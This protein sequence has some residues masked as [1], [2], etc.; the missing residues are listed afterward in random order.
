MRSLT[1]NTVGSILG[2]RLLQNFPQAQSLSFSTDSKRPGFNILFFAPRNDDHFRSF[3]DEYPKFIKEVRPESI[4]VTDIAHNPKNNNKAITSLLNHD[5]PP[6]MIMPHIV[7]IG[8]SKEEAD[9]KIRFFHDSGIRSI[10]VVRGNPEVLGKSP[11]YTRR[12]DGYEDMP[13]LMRRIK[14]L[15]PDMQINV[16]GYPGKHPY[17]R[18][19]AEDMDELKKKVDHGADSIITQHFFDNDIFLGFM[20]Q[21][22]KRGIN[23]PIIPSVLPIGNPKYLFSFSRAAGVDVPAQVT[24]ILFG[25]E[26]MTTKS[27]SITDLDVEKRAVEY[28]SKQ[29]QGLVDL[30]LP[31]VP[32]INTYAANNIPF[33]RKI[34]HNL[35]LVK[36]R[37][38]EKTR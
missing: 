4:S 9:E 18:S 16:A 33:L 35:G 17:A 25:Q 7:L 31:Q 1:K 15:S 14:D 13:H 2:S 11:D 30:K 6:S 3:N 29:I 20:D 8:H 26:G 19:F 28:T 21:C 22:Q 37:E 12:P 38:E 10:F 32:R 5:V 27:E 36:G 24:E 23:V 34:L